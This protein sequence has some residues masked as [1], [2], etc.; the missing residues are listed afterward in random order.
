MA[1]KLYWENIILYIITIVI[2][3][4]IA[5]IPAPNVLH[6]PSL[7]SVGLYSNYI[8]FQIL[9]IDYNTAIFKYLG[10][11]IFYIQKNSLDII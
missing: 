7:P 10:N 8:F 3:P 2:I 4:A 5:S 1:I 9:S 11:I 6:L